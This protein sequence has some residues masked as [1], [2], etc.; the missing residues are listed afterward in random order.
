M[1]VQFLVGVTCVLKSVDCS[2]LK[3]V[4]DAE[5][6]LRYHGAV[7]VPECSSSMLESALI[8]LNSL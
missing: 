4:T 8:P 3:S 2:S 7:E 6:N 1:F 5:K